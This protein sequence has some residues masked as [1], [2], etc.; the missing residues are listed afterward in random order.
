MTIFC[1]AVCDWWSLRSTR[2]RH[3]RTCG[4][5]T[6]GLSHC[7]TSWYSKFSSDFATVVEPLCAVLRN[8]TDTKFE[9]TADADFSFVGIKRLTVN[10]PALSM[11]D[12]ELPTN[13]TSDFASRRLSP[14]ERKYSAVEH[15]ALVCVWAVERWRTYLFWCYVQI[16]EPSWH[17]NVTY[18]LEKQNVPA[19]CLSRLPLYS[20]GDPTEGPDM[21]AA[22]FKESPHVISVS[23]FT[24][25]TANAGRPKCKKKVAPELAP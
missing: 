6:T 19:E 7:C 11:Y 22:V 17:H 10:S 25:A 16:P 13:V 9:W 4:C 14:A 20:T 5:I 2:K 1:K 24:A 12:P 18:Y 3:H 15:E 21:V 23:E 8:S